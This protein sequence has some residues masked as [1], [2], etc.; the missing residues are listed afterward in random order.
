M[1]SFGARVG[2][3]LLLVLVSAVSAEAQNEPGSSRSD[4]SAVE[5]RFEGL[6][7]SIDRGLAYLASKQGRDGS[8]PCEDAQYQAP[9]A[10]TALSLLAFLSAG[11]CEGRGPYGEVVQKAIDYLL[12][13]QRTGNDGSAGYISADGDTTSKMHGHGYATLALAEAYGMSS[14]TS[15]RQEIQQALRLAVRRIEQSQGDEGAWWY[16]PR[17]F[18]DSHENSITITLIQALRASKNCGIF[19]EPETIWKA[20]EYVRRSQLE[21]GSFTYKLHDP[22]SSFALTA[23]AVSTLNSVGEYDSK[24]IDRAIDYMARTDPDANLR[25]GGLTHFE[26]YSRLYAAQAYWQYRDQSQWNRWYPRTKALL[27]R[28]QHANGSWT[29]LQYGSE[30][31]TAMSLIVLAVPYQYLP[32]FQR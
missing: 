21:D 24:M 27:F 11:H 8:F 29:S 15:V 23:A 31:A 7:E 2:A 13:Q 19:V 22:R 4:A 17:K 26:F 18:K 9:T 20:L 32:I 30:Y 6:S 12:D 14:R 16:E 25:D 28:R 10:V 1:R 5:Q 3:T